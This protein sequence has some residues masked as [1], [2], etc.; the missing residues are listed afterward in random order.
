[1][2][3]DQYRDAHNADKT[4]QTIV[5]VPLNKAGSWKKRAILAIGISYAMFAV[6]AISAAIGIWP[7]MCAVG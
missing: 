2:A 7:P 4:D 3:Q 6:G 5:A 1:M